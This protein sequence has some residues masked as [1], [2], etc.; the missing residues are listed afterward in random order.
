MEIKNAILHIIKNDGSP[1]V[2]SESELDID[3]E[4]CEAFISK[5]VK[6]LM[7][8]PAAREAT[9][10]ADSAIYQAIQ[11]Y[12]NQETN[13]KDF[14]YTCA[15]RL[16]A[17]LNSHGDI[18]QADLLVVRFYEK[19]DQYVAIF[20]L[21]YNECFTHETGKLGNNLIKCHT[22]LPF[23]SGKVE[24]ACL[25]PFSPMLITLIEKAHNIGG[26]AVNYFSEFYLECESS[27]SRKETAQIISE[28]TDE[29]VQEFFDS[30][31][32]TRALFKTAI[33]EEAEEA[34]GI[35][36][37]DNVAARVFEDENVKRDFV[38]TIRDAGIVE[39]MPL[40]AK[41]VK[42]QF[43]THR[44]KAENGIEVK[45]PAEIAM[46]DDQMN[47]ENHSDGSVTLTLKRLRMQV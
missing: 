26:E 46:D 45:F 29:F 44:L 43:G 5:H 4:V 41:F 28:V 23:N 39:D 42:Q 31:I 21:N 13:F 20:K 12:I 2:Y 1:S 11:S 3:S 16:E 9:F 7:R 8:N 30:D 19:H 15:S 6:K 22:V 27:L 36:S 32:K 47:I 17:I 40:G 38:H 18:P 33:T 25:I 37:M 35:V 14:A 24:E 34:D 10:K